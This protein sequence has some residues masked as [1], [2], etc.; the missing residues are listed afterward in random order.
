VEQSVTRV[1]PYLAF[2]ILCKNKEL[3]NANVSFGTAYASLNPRHGEL[4]PS[5][6]P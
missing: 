4:Y 3:A 1:N 2:I 5:P 6:H